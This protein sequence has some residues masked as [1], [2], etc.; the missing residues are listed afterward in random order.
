MILAPIWG[1]LMLCDRLRCFAVKCLVTC[2]AP[3]KRVGFAMF[4]A[5]CCQHDDDVVDWYADP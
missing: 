2:D 4:Q 3:L 5:E 1:M